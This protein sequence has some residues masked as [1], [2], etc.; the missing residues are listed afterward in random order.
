V[1]F[2]AALVERVRERL[3]DRSGVTDKRMFG[4]FAF[5]T[6]GNLTVCVRGDDLM[7]RV[8]PDGT[9]DALARPGARQ[10][11]MTGR[12][13][14]GWVLVDGAFLDDDVLTEWIDRAGDFVRT[15]PPK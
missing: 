10:M 9:A 4:T 2:D 15:L 13:M 14:K 12:P 7:V 6:D 8:G 1:A 3:A 11:D 5:L